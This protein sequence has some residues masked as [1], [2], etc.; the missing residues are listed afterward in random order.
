MNTLAM[1]I[2]NCYW[3]QDY[4]CH[5]TRQAEKKALESYSQKQGKASTSSLATTPQNKTNPSLVALSAKNP[6][7]KSSLSTVSSKDCSTSVT[8]D[9]LAAAS[10]K[11]SEK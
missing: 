4:E 8:A 11:H 1:T 3:E 9:T 2:D 5:R 7:S 10:E 6:S